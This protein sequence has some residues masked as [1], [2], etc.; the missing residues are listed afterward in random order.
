MS[1][2]DKKII[3]FV[4]MISCSIHLGAINSYD[5]YHYT[6]FVNKYDNGDLSA[7]LYKRES[8]GLFP[9]ATLTEDKN[10][11]SSF[12]CRGYYGWRTVDQLMKYE[13]DDALRV[14][15]HLE[16]EIQEYKKTHGE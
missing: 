9:Q 11:N 7:T 5:T 3:Y 4:L 14:K 12:S 8:D 6:I 13:R 10:G 1:I 15:K 2:L 16:Q